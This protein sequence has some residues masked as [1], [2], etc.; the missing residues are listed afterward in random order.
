MHAMFYSVAKML[1]SSSK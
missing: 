1:Q